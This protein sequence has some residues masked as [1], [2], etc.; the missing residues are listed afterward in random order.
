MKYAPSV[1]PVVE[2][3]Q[4]EPHWPWFLTAVTAP[5]LVQ[6]I[7]SGR[8]TCDGA[9]PVHL[10]VFPRVFVVVLAVYAKLVR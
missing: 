5:F 2:K 9:F 8:S 3:A 7:W 10:F 1:E 4:Q 6:S